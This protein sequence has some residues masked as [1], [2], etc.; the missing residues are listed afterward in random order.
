MHPAV[1]AILL[2]LASEYGVKA[3]RLTREDLSVSLACNPRNQ[4]RKRWESFIFTQLSRAAEQKLRARSIVFPDAVFGLHQS[5]DVHERYVLDLFPHLRGGSTELYCH[6]AFL[7]CKEAQ[8]WTP[9]Y[10]RDVELVTL[11]STAV[12]A[13]LTEQGIRL[14]SYRDL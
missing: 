5:G 7:P 13:A 2:D 14:I 11:T 8:Y 6:P 1:L 3:M 9:S 10:R 12:R 4:L